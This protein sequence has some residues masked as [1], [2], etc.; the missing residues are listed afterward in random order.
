MVRK[1]SFDSV[2][3]FE[4]FVSGNNTKRYYASLKKHH[5]EYENKSTIA[6]QL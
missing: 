1:N 2:E 4:H 5:A 3:G 6:F